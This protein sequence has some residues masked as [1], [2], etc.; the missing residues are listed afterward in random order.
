MRQAV[1]VAAALILSAGAAWAQEEDRKKAD[2]LRREFEKSL[3]ALEEKF[4]TERARLEK[5]FKAAREKLLPPDEKP[6]K[7]GKKVEKKLE[8][9]LDPKNLEDLVQ[10]LLDRV[11]GL[12]KKLEGQLPRLREFRQFIPPREQFKDFDFKGFGERMPQEW[13]KWLEQ[14]PRFKDENF[15]FEFRRPAPKEEKKEKE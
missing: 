5:E 13:R 2:D 8:K 3:K 4:A 12:E 9:K 11:E 14:M 1:G 7:E 6:E 15:K 10:K